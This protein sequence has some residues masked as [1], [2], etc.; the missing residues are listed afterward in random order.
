[1]T[2]LKFE[3]KLEQAGTY[4]LNISV[5]DEAGNTTTRTFSFEVTADEK[6]SVD[7][8]EV[9]GGVL[10]GLSVAILAGVVIYF[11][12]SKVKLDKKEKRYKE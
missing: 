11:V 6:S 12:V 8:K 3:Y 1:M 9:M 10:I 5:E 7:V 4:T 2:T